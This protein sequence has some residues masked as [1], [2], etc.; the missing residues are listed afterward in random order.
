MRVAIDARWHKTGL[1]VYTK[2]LLEHLRALPELKMHGI[3][4]DVSAPHFGSLCDSTSTIKA[5]GYSIR[6]HWEIPSTIQRCDLFHATHYN[7]PLLYSGPLVVSIHD[8][9]HLTPEGSEGRISVFA[10]AQAMLRLAVRKADHVITV[11]QYS[12]QCIMERLRVS[13]SK[14]TVI[15]NGMSIEFGVFDKNEARATALQLWHGKRRYLL[16][17]CS[18]RP[19]K[20][21]VRLLQACSKFWQRTQVDWN[22][23]IVGNGKRAERDRLSVECQ[24]LKISDR[25]IIVPFVADREL[26][27]IY[28]GAEFVVM[29]SL[30]E[31]FGFPV[32]EAMASGTPVACSQST[33]LPEIGGDAVSYFDPLSPDDMARAMELILNEAV[34]SRMI[35]RGLER[36]A[37]FSWNRSAREHYRVYR[38]IAQN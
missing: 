28:G 35:E 10:Y 20:N 23:V 18:L 17:V 13:E 21:L 27:S 3:V 12:K 14:V 11:S 36:S 15:P 22:L 7:V 37:M 26:K 24:H 34:A 30:S 8:L 16:C 33:S 1:G 19:H 29:P 31:G 32:L 5:R 4:S 6:E 9:T 25:V 38:S 2:N